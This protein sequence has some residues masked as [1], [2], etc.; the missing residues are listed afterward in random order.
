MHSL[1]GTLN[2]SAWS[3]H[4]D[5]KKSKVM[6]FL[7][8]HLS[9]LRYEP[10]LSHHRD[11][12]SVVAK[13]DPNRRHN[14]LFRR[15]NYQKIWKW[16]CEWTKNEQSSTRS[17]VFCSAKSVLF[18]FLMHKL[19][20]QGSIIFFQT[21]FPTCHWLF[22]IVCEWF[23]P[24]ERIQSCTALFSE[25]APRSFPPHNKLASVNWF[26]IL[27]LIPIPG[28]MGSNPAVLG[29]VSGKLILAVGL[30]QSTLWRGLGQRFVL[31]SFALFLQI[32]APSW[33][34]NKRNTCIRP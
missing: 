14:T 27:H 25:A 8:Q 20:S 17:R 10:Y 22:V 28:V 33:T 6:A 3:F 12:A 7:L 23:L 30:I 16:C 1:W 2:V 32:S 13:V 15:S 18:V 19:W 31:D 29:V 26:H 11:Q 24:P 21:L 5:E 9:V 34:G 4:W